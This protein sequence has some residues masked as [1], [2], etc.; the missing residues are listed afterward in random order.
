LPTRAFA[1]RIRGDQTR[2]KILEA[3]EIA[4]A[5]KGYH[6]TVVDEIVRRTAISKG[7]VYFHFP[8]KEELFFAVM[9]NLAER[10][11]RRV[12]AEMEKQPRPLDKLDVAL[13]TV[14]ESLSRRRRLARLL[15]LQGYSMGNAFEKKR[16]EIFS[17]FAL[18]V[19]QG[20]AQAVA[21]GDISPVDTS[22][23]AFAWLGAINE[24]VIRWLLTGGPEPVQEAMPVLRRLLF[25]GIGVD[26]MDTPI[27]DSIVGDTQ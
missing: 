12:E 15:L 10:L 24:V 1:E 17:R 13:T 20:L 25:R 16:I 8:S 4:F 27:T 3:A 22:I 23:V 7:G 14:L 26:L 11:V 18:L 6:D 9:D 21:E 19:K 5:E 2:D